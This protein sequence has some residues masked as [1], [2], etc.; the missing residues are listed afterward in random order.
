[1]MEDYKEGNIMV[2]ANYLFFCNSIVGLNF[3]GTCGII[4]VTMATIFPETFIFEGPPQA[5]GPL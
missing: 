1:M 5:G 2:R 3:K 4:S